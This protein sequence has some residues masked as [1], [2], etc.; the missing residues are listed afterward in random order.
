M[1][2]TYDPAIIFAPAKHDIPRI[3]EVKKAAQALAEV[4]QLQTHQSEEQTLAFQTV[5]SAVFWAQAAINRENRSPEK[6]GSK[7]NPAK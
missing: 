4:I 2:A 7:K 6:K 5:L 3:I 1:T